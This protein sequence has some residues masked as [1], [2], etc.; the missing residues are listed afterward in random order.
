[1]KYH[2]L[3]NVHHKHRIKLE[4]EKRVTRREFNIKK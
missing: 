2:Q 1:M 3:I 4:A